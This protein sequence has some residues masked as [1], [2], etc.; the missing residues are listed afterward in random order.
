MVL[1]GRKVLSLAGVSYSC[2]AGHFV[3]V[4]HPDCI[5]MEAIPDS[6]TNQFQAWILGFDQRVVDIARLVLSMHPTDS[7]KPSESISVGPLS[8]I[9]PCVLSLIDLLDRSHNAPDPA[10]LDLAFASILVAL[11]RCG[12]DQFLQ[13]REPSLG[14]KIRKLVAS[15]P[16]RDWLSLHFERE[17]HLSGATLRRKLSDEGTSLRELLREGRLLHGLSLLQST[18]QPIKTVAFRSGYRSV[19][20]FRRN[21]ADRFG[22]DA[23]TVAQTPLAVR[24]GAAVS[25]RQ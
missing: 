19:A 9:L 3:M 2:D 16:S 18:Q 6:E 14:A 20:S 10:A 4:H 13:S 7:G 17:L 1:S 22:V 25:A 8:V 23:S 11:G 24:V 15:N 12:M 21:F 5:D